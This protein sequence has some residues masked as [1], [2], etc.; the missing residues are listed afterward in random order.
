ML[1]VTL[2]GGMCLAAPYVVLPNGQKVQGS[3]VKVADGGQI[4]LTTPKGV[5]TFPKGTSVFVDEPPAYGRAVTLMEQGQYGEAASLLEGITVEYR[6][7]QWDKR[8]RKLL[9]DAY[10]KSDQF[11]K[12][13]ATYEQVFK[14]SPDVDDGESR[15]NYLKALMGSGE[16][17]KLAPLLDKAIAES[18]RSVA[19]QAQMMRGKMRLDAGDVEG[20]LFDFMRTAVFFRQQEAV[21]PE[22]TFRTAQCLEKMGND[23]AGEFY[24]RVV[25]EFPDSPFAAQARQKQ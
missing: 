23:R 4:L 19:A 17:D 11:D 1:V 12:A 10:L 2:A 22:A 9:A 24:A 7:L 8:A 15:A 3:S 5:L 25:S 6:M 20:A 21:L 13:V 16:Y 18:P 14:E